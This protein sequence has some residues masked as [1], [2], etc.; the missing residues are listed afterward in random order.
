MRDPHFPQI[1]IEAEPMIA[2][3]DSLGVDVSVWRA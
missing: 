1:R 3:L 2:F